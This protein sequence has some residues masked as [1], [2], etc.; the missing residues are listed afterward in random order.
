MLGATNRND[1][2]SADKT[3]PTFSRSLREINITKFPWTHNLN[4]AAHDPNSQGW[5]LRD[6]FLSRGSF[7]NQSFAQIGMSLAKAPSRD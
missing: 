7:A 4:Q 1:V 5:G 2:D 3:S 6:F